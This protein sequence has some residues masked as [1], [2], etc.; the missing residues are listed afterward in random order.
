MVRRNI[1]E[2]TPAET[3]KLNDRKNGWPIHAHMTGESE[4]IAVGTTSERA[5][6]EVITHKWGLLI[7]TN[8]SS[9]QIFPTQWKWFY[10]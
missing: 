7:P 10:K 2:R 9:L 1:K 6:T 5:V 8:F 4:I 3:S